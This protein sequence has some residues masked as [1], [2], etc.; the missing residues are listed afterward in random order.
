MNSRKCEWCGKPFFPTDKKQRF[1]STECS[2]NSRAYNNR[3]ALL[4]S[5]SLEQIAIEAN[6]RGLSYGEYMRVAAADLQAW[7]KKRGGKG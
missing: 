5:K 4:E 2:G 3:K 1:C 6:E 7:K